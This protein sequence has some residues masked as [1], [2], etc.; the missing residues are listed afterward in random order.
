MPVTN[1]KQRRL[2][3]FRNF[4]KG[5]GPAANY[6]MLEPSTYAAEFCGKPGGHPTFADNL[7]F[8]KAF[9]ND[10]PLTEF[11]FPDAIL[12][13]LCWKRTLLEKKEEISFFEET[14]QVPG[15]GPKTRVI[16]ENPGTQPWIV[17]APVQNESDFD[18]I[19]YYAECVKNNTQHYAAKFGT[20]FDF[21]KREGFMASAV[22]LIPFEAYY[23]VDYPDMPL[24]FYDFTD[25]YLRSI[26]NVHQANMAVAKTLIDAGCEMFYMGS[27]G[28]ELLSPRIF[29]EAIIPFVRETTDYI[30]SRGAFA[31]YHI[32]GHSYQLLKSGRINTIRPTWFET[33][34]SPPCGNNACLRESLNYLSED[35]IS[36][37]NLSLEILRNG[38]P[39]D[40]K[41]AT[42]EIIKGS[43]GRRHIIGQAD[44]TIL[45]GTPQANIRAFLDA[46]SN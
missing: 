20:L 25:R 12:P 5:T 43:R 44:A 13:Q 33:F 45:S 2:E 14:L 37:G 40:I 6:I 22:L 11:V 26:K 19:D 23:L 18:L 32:C 9:V 27:A 29:D 35:I 24:F 16:A 21:C 42:H 4:V 17:K 1:L 39:Q 38:T 34:S 3:S 30:H 7:A 28:L 31:N 8:H 10:S 46:A 36:K 41:T 15:S